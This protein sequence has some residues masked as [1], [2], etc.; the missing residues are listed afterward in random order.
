VTLSRELALLL[1]G[2][3]TTAEAG[4]GPGPQSKQMGRASVEGVELEYEVRGTGEPV[5]LIHNGVGVDW[6]EPLLAEPALA[7]RS[8]LI[9]YHRAGYAG[10]GRVGGPIDFAQEAA[11]CRALLRHL[12][13]PRA[14]V[15]GHSS[16]A[17]IALKLA[18]D[19]P[20]SVRSLGLL[21]P[22][23]MTVPSPTEVPRALELFRAGDK[24][25][26][27]DSFFRGTCGDGYRAALDRAQPGA[28]DSA[29]A[30]ADRFFGQELPALRQLVFGP[31]EAKRVRQP[32][33]AVLGARTGD[34]HRKRHDLL[35]QW[36]PT[37]E[38]FVLPAAGHLLHLE[39]PR[40]M[41]EGLAAFF[42]RHP[43]EPRTSVASPPRNPQ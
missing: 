30:G 5:V 37:V 40:G 34:R 3:V 31:D 15:V 41:A 28:F 19:A 8:R 10:S 9:T 16:S 14:H 32:A 11:H 25:G 38:P 4:P 6:Y 20:D 43:I 24:A 22:A 13:V 2:L 7:R 35:L 21:E 33:L 23:L 18:L 29:L 39:N 1:A 27:M 42:T 36:L 26:A 12:G 17:M